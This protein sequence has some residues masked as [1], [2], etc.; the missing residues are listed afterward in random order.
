M[1]SQ[2]LNSISAIT[3]IIV[4]KTCCRKYGNLLATGNAEKK[5]Y[6]YCLNY[7]YMYPQDKEKCP[8][9]RGVPLIEVQRLLWALIVPGQIKVSVPL[10]EVSQSRLEVPL[11]V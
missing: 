11:S 8:L 4:R 3:Y 7:M 6:Q 9:N 2:Y 5:I 1:T 10:M